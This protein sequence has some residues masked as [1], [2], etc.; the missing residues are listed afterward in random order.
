MNVA[1]PILAPYPKTIMLRDG[2][3]V[4]VRP[5]IPEDKTR[6]LQF[7]QRVSEEEIRNDGGRN[8]TLLP[9]APIAAI[10]QWHALITLAASNIR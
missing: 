1:E 5:L 6:L 4:I 3:D 7:F 9:L 2:A 10:L 8:D